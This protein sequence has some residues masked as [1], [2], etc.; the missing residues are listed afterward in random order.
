MGS[1]FPVNEKLTREETDFPANDISNSANA[2]RVR[3]E[4]LMTENKGKIDVAAGERFLADHYDTYRQKDRARRA[5]TV[6]AYR[7]FAARRPA[8]ATALRHRRRSHQQSLRFGDGREADASRRRG[9]CLWHSLQ[10]RRAF[11]GASRVRLAET[12]IW[13]T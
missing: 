9:P 10:G 3:W 7:S 6:R 11:E 4:Q 12:D 5:H 1:N 8:L 2:R 13:S